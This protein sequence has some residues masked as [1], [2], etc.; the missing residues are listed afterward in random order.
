MCRF[1]TFLRRS[2]D[3]PF[4][5]SRFATRTAGKMVNRPK[6]IVYILHISMKLGFLSE[7]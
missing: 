3:V 4:M 7:S 5:Q 1:K 6:I 2:F